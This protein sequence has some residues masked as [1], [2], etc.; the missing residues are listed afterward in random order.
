VDQHP[1]RVVAAEL[2]ESCQEVAHAT[3]LP[4]PRCE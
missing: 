3:P 4:P 2:R 1:L